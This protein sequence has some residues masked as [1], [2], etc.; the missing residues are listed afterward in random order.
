M[1]PFGRLNIYLSMLSAF[2]DV[3]NR[4]SKF[5]GSIS[6]HLIN[7]RSVLAV[8]DATSARS[9]FMYAALEE[10]SKY[11]P[12]SSSADSFANFTAFCSSSASSRC[13]QSLSLNI[14]TNE[15]ISSMVL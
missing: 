11:G 15:N 14:L 7:V 4:R 1:S 3:L 8:L 2:S 10:S 6:P 13:T 5:S 9:F 12:A